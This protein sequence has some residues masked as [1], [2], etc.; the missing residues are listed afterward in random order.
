MLQE[1]L[2]Q[3]ATTVHLQFRPILLLKR[4]YFLDNIAAQ[5]YTFLPRMLTERIRG[6][7]LRRFVNR[8][9]TLLVRPIRCE[10]LKSLSSQ[11]KIERLAHLFTHCLTQGVIEVRH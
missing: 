11:Q 9:L 3:V 2:N 7:V 8:I 10:Y 1:R 4:P 5:K 6:N